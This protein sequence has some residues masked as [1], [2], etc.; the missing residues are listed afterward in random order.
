VIAPAQYS[1]APLAYDPTSGTW[2][3][4]SAVLNVPAMVTIVVI[5]ALLVVGIRES[6][7]VNNLV[8]VIKIAIILIFIATSPA[9]HFVAP[10]RGR[11]GDI[12]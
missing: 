8:V 9:I 12:H 3:T 2:Q 5:S 10:R 6:A 1:H 4:T 7:R 11:L